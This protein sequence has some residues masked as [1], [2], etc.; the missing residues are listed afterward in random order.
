M[1]MMQIG[2]MI[3][4]VHYGFYPYMEHLLEMEACQLE[5]PVILPQYLRE[6]VTLLRWK[7]WDRELAAHPDPRF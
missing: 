4:G 1:V 5:C 3:R 7:E 6:V 2:V